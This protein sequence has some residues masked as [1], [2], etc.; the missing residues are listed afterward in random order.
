MGIQFWYL[1]VVRGYP[2]GAKTGLRRLVVFDL[3]VQQA[4]FQLSESQ[5]GLISKGPGPDW[6]MIAK[7]G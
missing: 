6:L 4:F 5:L 1:A 3:L 2:L 7:P